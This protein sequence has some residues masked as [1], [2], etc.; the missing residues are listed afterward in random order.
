MRNMIYVL[1]S[2]K[3]FDKRIYISKFVSDK[4]FMPVYQTMLVDFHL[5]KEKLLDD[6]IILRCSEMWVFG[7][8]DEK[9]KEE[10]SVAR[11]LGKPVKHFDI[12]NVHANVY[13][14]EERK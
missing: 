8:A 2:R 5:D 6:K 3:D 14:I 12:T 10:I 4:G 11:R 7:K 1:I 13:D 9:M